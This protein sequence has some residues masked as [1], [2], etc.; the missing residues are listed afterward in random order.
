MSSGRQVSQAWA[1]SCEG[2]LIGMRFIL[3]M[4]A[5]TRAAQSPPVMRHA[6]MP[7]IDSRT[8]FGL[9]ACKLAGG[10]LDDLGGD[11]LLPHLPLDGLQS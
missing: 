1:V 6:N 11:R 8:G 3:A 9:T 10:Q 7:E 2:G 4:L 5:E